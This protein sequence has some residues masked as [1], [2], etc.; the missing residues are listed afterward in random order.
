MDINLGA[1][2]NGLEVTEKIRKMEGYSLV[3]IIAVTAFVFPGDKEEFLNR[4]CTHYLAKPFTKKDLTTL[5]TNV[6]SDF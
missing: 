1:G 4:G 5:V 6:L 2:M 3:P